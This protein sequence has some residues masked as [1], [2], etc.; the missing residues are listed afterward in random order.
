MSMNPWE[1]LM[2]FQ[3]DTTTICAI[4]V[5]GLLALGFVSLCIYA[6]CTAVCQPKYLRRRQEERRNRVKKYRRRNRVSSTNITSHPGADPTARRDRYACAA[7]DPPDLEEDTGRRMRTG[8]ENIS[9]GD[10]NTVGMSSRGRSKAAK[11]NR[12]QKEGGNESQDKRRQRSKSVGDGAIRA[13]GEKGRQRS[14]SEGTQ[15]AGGGAERH[16]SVS[17]STLASGGGRVRQ[18]SLSGGSSQS[19]VSSQ[20]RKRSVSIERQKSAPGGIPNAPIGRERLRSSSGAGGSMARLRY[21]RRLSL[22]AEKAKREMKM[23]RKKPI[24]RRTT[25]N[26]LA[27]V[28]VVNE[29]EE[30]AIQGGAQGGAHSRREHSRRE[31]AAK[32]TN[33]QPPSGGERKASDG[34]P[35]KSRDDVTTEETDLEISS[36][37]LTGLQDGRGTVGGA[38]TAEMAEYASPV[39]Q[40]GPSRKC[41]SSV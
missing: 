29:S 19:G 40:K 7:D 26:L 8:G 38:A 15:E 10:V 20:G 5:G 22:N 28:E 6:A 3:L 18:R 32:A 12:K 13:R 21:A 24:R 33:R 1:E 30:A 16:A 36:S 39:K 4:F 17:V 14:V 2:D 41:E 11:K 34:S 27:Q 35:A 37:S 31:G 23:K 25:R 9:Q